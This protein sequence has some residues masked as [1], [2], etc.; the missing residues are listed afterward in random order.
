MAQI[1]TSKV[2]DAM[3]LYRQS[4]ALLR[5]GIEL[6]DKTLGQ[7]YAQ[8]AELLSV[9]NPD[10]KTDL[11]KSALISFDDTPMPMQNPAHPKNIQQ[12][13]AWAILDLFGRS[14]ADRVL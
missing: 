1:M 8:G 7:W 9:F 13:S 11:L 10:A 6:S 2:C 3:P 5:R 14:R 12:H 4:T